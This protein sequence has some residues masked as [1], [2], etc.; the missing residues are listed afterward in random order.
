M[1]LL[2]FQTSAFKGINWLVE[3]FDSIMAKTAVTVILFLN[4]YVLIDCI[5]NKVYK[6][7]E[8]D[9]HIAMWGHYEGLDGAICNFFRILCDV[10][11]SKD[12]NY[13]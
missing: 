2:F 12:L 9:D 1:S 8:Q 6:L 5:K 7:A 3:Q 10:D 11:L 13:G 4:E